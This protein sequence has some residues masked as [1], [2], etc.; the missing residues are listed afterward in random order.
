MFPSPPTFQAMHQLGYAFL[1]FDICIVPLEYTIG[2]EIFSINTQHHCSHYKWQ[3]YIV[4]K[5]HYNKAVYVTN[6]TGNVIPAAKTD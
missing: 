1:W 6:I 4:R 2:A 5:K 3:L